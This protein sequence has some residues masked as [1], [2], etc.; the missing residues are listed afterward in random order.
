[1]YDFLNKLFEQPFF[2]K[3]VEIAKFFKL[4]KSYWSVASPIIVFLIGQ[5]IGLITS[6][7]IGKI[8]QEQIQS[9]TVTFIEKVFWYFIEIV[10][11]K[12]AWWALVLGIILLVFVSLVRYYEIKHSKSDSID[13]I[14]YNKFFESFDFYKQE[15]ESFSRDIEYIDDDNRKSH[16]IQIRNE[17]D[18]ICFAGKSSFIRVE[19]F[20]GIGKTRFVYE[21]LNDEKYKKFVLYIQSYKGSTLADLKMFCKKLPE[22]SQAIVIFVIDEC[23]YDDH[24]KIYRH[25]KT[26]PNLV[27]ITIDQ[28]FSTQDKIHCQDEKRIILKGLEEAETVKLIQEVNH[29]LNDDLAK[30]IAYYTDGYPGLAYFMA[31]SFDIEK[32]DTNN[33]DF[34]SKLLDD[35]LNKITDKVE[36]IKILQAISIFKMFPNTGEFSQYKK[37]IF[38]HLGIDNASASITIKSFIRKGI[39]REAGRFLY[40]SPR[41]ISIHL[42]NQF[43]EI[44]DY[45]FINELFQKL[46]NEGLMNSFFEKLQGVQFDTP[47]HK[48]LLFQI[49]SKLTYEQ[50][51]DGFGSKIFYA[52]CLKDRKYSIGILEEMLKDK[53]KE[54]LLKLEEGRRY[55]VHALEEL[56][57]FKDTYEDSIKIL[58]Q[59]ARAENESWSNNSKG[60]FTETFQWILGGTEVNIVKRLELLKS[61][62]QEF[63][64]DEDRLILLEALETSYPKHN[65]MATHKNHSTFPEN[66]PKNYYP[67][68]QDEIDAYFEKLKELITFAY[69]NSSI[70]LQSKILNDLLQ[71]S[72]MMMR[73]NQINIWFLEFIENLLSVHPY[74]KSLL[75]EEISII[76]E[77]DKDEKLSKNILNKLE[78][79]CNKFTNTKNIEETKELFF[80]TERYRYKSEEAFEKHCKVIAQDIWVNRNYIGLLEKSTSNV[81]DLGKELAKMDIEGNLYEDILNLIPTLTK[82]S[83][84][85]FI[86]AYLFNSPIDTNGYHSMFD[87]IYTKLDDKSLMFDFIHYSKP[88]EVSIKYLYMLLE[89]KEIE[90]HMLENLTFGFWLRDLTKHEFINF[91]DGLNSR[92]E[93]KCNSFDLCMQYVHHQKDKELVEKYTIYYIENHIFNCTVKYRVKHYIEEMIDKYFAY[94]LEFTDKLLSNIWEAILYE[95]ENEGKFEDRGFHSI[96]KIIQKYPDFFWEKIKNKLDEL[97]PTTYPLYSRFIYFMQGGYLSHWYNHSIFSY[98]NPDDVINWLKT[99][100]YQKAKY[101]VADSLNID[102][103]SDT[104][105]DIVIKLLTEFPNDEDLYSSIQTRSESWSGS[106]VPV[107]NEKISNITCMLKLYEDNENV[108][109]FL[110]WSKKG[111]ENQR[112]R[113]QIRDEEEYLLS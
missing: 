38:E 100:H 94:N 22:N 59:L 34:K 88:T 103:K 102:F 99:T 80:Q 90:S 63:T 55:L 3:I 101:I 41:P 33:P 26:Y 42:F 51:S 40:I 84:N 1:M 72:R 104:L 66:I 82:N 85:R 46:N 113:E 110:K 4:Q 71:S 92:I 109:E 111:Y 112:D 39:V 70:H 32:G 56:I 97:K 78:S 44:S 76:L 73:Y 13:S 23:S 25:L 86:L 91:I 93:N 74:L 8:T 61:L 95:F 28:V 31:E 11:A 98:I 105:P 7:N 35:I 10:F 87:D 54:N 5:M 30:K 69:E 62:Y 60:I 108:V 81:F 27:V 37:I 58:F 19:G 47:Q 9:E 79:L 48:D 50:I 96:Y 16:I 45:G 43:I 6:N 29:L 68:T 14:F 77:C 15:I 67:K 21:A 17:I 12:G 49:L 83:N 75:F 24:V 57:A 52:L 106:Y 89:K 53:T 20:S 2:K 107:A 64:S 36:D 65:Y 18:N